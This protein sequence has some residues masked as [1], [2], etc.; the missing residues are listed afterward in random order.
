MELDLDALLKGETDD[1]LAAR[2]AHHGRER[3]R[4]LFAEDGGKILKT[5]LERQIEVLREPIEDRPETLTAETCR[6]KLLE[7]SVLK[8]ILRI[9]DTAAEA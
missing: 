5:V 6:D 9:P 1:G 7:I 4:F 8:A 2:N 3:L